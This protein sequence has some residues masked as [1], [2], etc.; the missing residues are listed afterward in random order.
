MSGPNDQDN[1]D[2]N[3]DDKNDDNNDDDD[4]DDDDDDNHGICPNCQGCGPL[5]IYCTSAECEDSGMI[6][7]F[8]DE[9]AA[10]VAENDDDGDDDDDVNLAF[11]A[12]MI[13]DLGQGR[14]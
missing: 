3:N 14:R 5:G 11:C 6:F 8:Y 12:F 2:D 1:N 9:D 4:D 7:D 10:S 13:Y